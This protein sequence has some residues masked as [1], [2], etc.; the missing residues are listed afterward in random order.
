VRLR[1]PIVT[2]AL[3]A[4]LAAPAAAAAPVAFHTYPWPLRPFHHEHPVRAN[5]GD[6]RTFFA[7]PLFDGGI[8]G[9]GA[10]SFHNGID[11]AGRDGT[12]VYP[13][14]S[15]TAKLINNDTAVSVS[16][17]K[18]R[19]FEYEHIVP[20]VR[21]GQQVVALKTVIGHIART[22]GHVHLTEI[23]EGHAWN[24]LAPG[25]IAPYRDTL[26]PRISA[27][28]FRPPASAFTQL[29]P[30]G[31]CGTVSIV[32]DALDTPQLRVPGTFAGFPVSPA[33]VSWSLRRFGGAAI[34]D[35]TRVADFRTTLPA[36]STFWS[37][38]ARGTYQNAPRFENRQFNLMPGRFIFQLTDALETRS[39]ANGV[40]LVSVK[41]SDIRGHTST[42]SQRFT[43][44]NRP[45]TETGCAG[46]VSRGK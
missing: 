42:L 30:L 36:A 15:G 18:G 41:A 23:R 39:L 3:T 9:P 21:D 43:V 5:F 2:A 40:Y 12:A 4:A 37:V 17:G 8:E 46:R 27:I 35:E 32:A 14:M 34:H 13:V 28:E 38:Y 45:G 22:F 6:P 1:L 26:K 25:G 31:I 29:D 24:P 11:I 16:T 20:A 33:V 44:V 19:V 10:F 7:A